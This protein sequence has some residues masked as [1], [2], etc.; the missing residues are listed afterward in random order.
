MLTSLAPMVIAVCAAAA[1]P[2]Q[3]APPPTE[4]P[5]TV[6]ADARKKTVT[7]EPLRN[8]GMR[9][10]PPVA[11]TPRRSNGLTVL[12]DL[13]FVIAGAEPRIVYIVSMLPAIR[14]APIDVRPNDII[15][16][17]NGQT[18]DTPQA[19]QSRYGRLR[20]GHA[21]ELRLRRG[22]QSVTVAFYKPTPEEPRGRAG[23]SGP[24]PPG[25][26]LFD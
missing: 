8:R 18:I 20:P 19:F 14:G 6:G 4:K 1:N 9:S 2:Q 16:A 11:S 3:Q 17:L 25:F 12:N 23:P 13:G 21:V 5:P 22:E 15:L 26:A 7:G 10:L 24:E